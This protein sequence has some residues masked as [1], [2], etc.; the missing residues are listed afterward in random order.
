[1]QNLSNHFPNEVRDT[2]AVTLELGIFQ[3]H[4]S[5][6][7]TKNPHVKKNIS[8]ASNLALESQKNYKLYPNLSKLYKLFLTAPPS[9]CKSE[10]SFSRLKLLKSYLRNRMSEKKLHYLMFLSCEK[11]LTDKLDLNCLA[12]KWKDMKSRRIQI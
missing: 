7:L 12:D 10:R 3:N 2:E 6:Y 8:S 9:V 5:D 1:M 11:D 4:F